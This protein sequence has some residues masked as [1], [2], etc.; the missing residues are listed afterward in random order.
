MRIVVY[1]IAALLAICL[2]V[3]GWGSS[4]PVAHTASRSARFD[5]PPDTVWRVITD[6]AAYP[7]WRSDVKS[8]ELLPAAAGSLAWRET[9]G[10]DMV[11]YA[12]DE[13]RAPARF[14]ARITDRSLPYGGRW[15]Y[16]LAP[17][18]NGTRLMTTEEGEVYNPIFRFMSR[19]VFGQT[20]TIEKYL[21]A[22]GTRLS[23]A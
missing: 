20:A 11:S 21:A 3:Y 16:E 18:G 6:V 22:L 19:Y 9:S 5:T 4:L 8:V 2:V 10:R 15:V 1:A 14:V 17:A 23:H 7:S 13:M 12:A